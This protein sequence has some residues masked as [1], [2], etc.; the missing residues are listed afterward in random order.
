[1][2]EFEETALDQ[3]S[4]EERIIALILKAIFSWRAYFSLSDAAM[5]FILQSMVTILQ[6]LCLFCNSSQLT[7]LTQNFP[8]TL[9]L[10]RKTMQLKQDHFENFVV[11]P[12]CY[13]L[14]DYNTS[15]ESAKGEWLEKC[16]WKTF[17][18]H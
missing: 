18:I 11:C 16:S 10:A 17:I 15:L 12:K 6:A 4:E 7:K 2:D 13:T 9:Y 1:M 8:S 14:H 5:A 3:D